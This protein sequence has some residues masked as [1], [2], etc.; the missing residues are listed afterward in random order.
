M[1]W[2]NLS[3]V[4]YNWKV[5]LRLKDTSNKQPYEQQCIK[6]ATMSYE[7]FQTDHIRTISYWKLHLYLSLKV[8][9]QLYIPRL[10]WAVALFELAEPVCLELWIQFHHLMIHSLPIMDKKWKGKLDIKNEML[11]QDKISYINVLK[12]SNI[13]N[14]E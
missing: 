5:H 12:K 3:S 8:T 2:R 10:R 6:E 4:V 11:N 7:D 14:I 1:K 9:L 13:T